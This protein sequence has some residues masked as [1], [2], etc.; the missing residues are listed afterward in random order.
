LVWGF[1]SFKKTNQPASSIEGYASSLRVRF[2]VRST[3]FGRN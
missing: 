3:D 2:I 1:T